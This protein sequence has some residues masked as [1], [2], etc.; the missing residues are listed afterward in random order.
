MG[1][2]YVLGRLKK[3]TYHTCAVTCS[4]TEGRGSCVEEKVAEIS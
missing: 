2:H 4:H 1:T 3:R